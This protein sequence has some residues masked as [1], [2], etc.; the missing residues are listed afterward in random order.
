MLETVIS[1]KSIPRGAGPT[2]TRSNTV[3]SAA[4]STSQ[5]LQGLLSGRSPSV[6]KVLPVPTPTP[7]PPLPIPPA[8]PVPTPA[9]SING[10]SALQG[11]INGGDTASSASPSTLS[12]TSQQGV[13]AAQTEGKGPGLENPLPVSPPTTTSIRT[14]STL[15]EPT[16][17]ETTQASSALASELASNPSATVSLSHMEADG[18]DE[19]DG[20]GR[21]GT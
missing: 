19:R 2:P 6:D 14:T 10:D 18:G 9:N 13:P 7:P 20:D 15:T 12:L 5:R 3:N 1:E 16:A 11:G 4:S 21:S 8:N 17:A